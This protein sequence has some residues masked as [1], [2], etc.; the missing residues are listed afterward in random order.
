MNKDGLIF[1]GI[2]ALAGAI[3]AAYV[4]DELLGGGALGWVAGGA[5]L[6]GLAGPLFKT[7]LERRG[8]G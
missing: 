7:L 4:G 8:R 2:L 3:L 6:A 5:I 1:K